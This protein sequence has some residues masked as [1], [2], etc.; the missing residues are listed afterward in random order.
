M[1][2]LLDLLAGL[3]DAVDVI[4]LRYLF[5]VV[6]LALDGAPLGRGDFVTQVT[7]RLFGLVDQA[8][9]CVLDIDQL[10]ALLVFCFV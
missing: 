10:A 3:L 2:G 7:Q 9:C 5:E 6:D 4:A 8:V 1:E